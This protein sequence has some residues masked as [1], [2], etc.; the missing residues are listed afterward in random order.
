[1]EAYRYHQLAYLVLPIMVGIEF[2]LSAKE[3]KA[4]NDDT[5]LGYYLL[6][7]LGFVFA[8]VFPALFIFTIW[9]SVT[10]AF[11]LQALRIATLDR[12]AVLFFFMGAWWQVYLFGALRARRMRKKEL[13]RSYLWVP[14]VG[15]GVYISLLVLWG[16]PW[17]LKWVSAVWFVL[18]FAVLNFFSAKTVERSMWVLLVITF[19]V[20]NL[21]F[22]WFESL[23]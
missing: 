18:V 21:M 9:A 13:G 4:G 19:F 2:F 7:F 3:D 23:V 17:G 11:P 20:E 12:Y 15:L 5:S 10:K 14:F 1:M 6:D 16:S 8:A 22:I